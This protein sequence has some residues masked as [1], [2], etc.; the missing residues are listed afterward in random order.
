MNSLDSNEPKISTEQR[1]KIKEIFN[2]VDTDKNGYLNPN[3]VFT[4][5]LSSI[6]NSSLIQQITTLLPR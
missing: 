6:L 2:R 5:A 3:E 4:K 1:A